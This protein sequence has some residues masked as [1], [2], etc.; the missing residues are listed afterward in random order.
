MTF[1]SRFW[2][3]GYWVV[4]RSTALPHVERRFASEAPE[5]QRGKTNPR[6]RAPSP[7]G[8]DNGLQP[9]ASLSST[10]F[11]SNYFSE[12]TPIPLHE[13]LRA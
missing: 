9:V 5:K 4:F 8:W 2:L 7:Q 13:S 6:P 11:H 12:Y 3:Q 1:G 10:P